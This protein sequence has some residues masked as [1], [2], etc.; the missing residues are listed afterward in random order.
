MGRK[1]RK[2]SMS[3]GV[4]IKDEEEDGGTSSGM[5]SSGNADDDPTSDAAIPCLD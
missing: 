2:A 3:G 4:K 1:P 5:S